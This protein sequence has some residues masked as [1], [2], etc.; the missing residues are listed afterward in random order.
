MLKNVPTLRK[1][2]KCGKKFLPVD[3]G[4]PDLDRSEVSGYKTLTVKK[5]FHTHFRGLVISHSIFHIELWLFI[6]VSASHLLLTLTA[7][8]STHPSPDPEPRTRTPRPRPKPK[9]G[10]CAFHSSPES[11]PWPQGQTG[12]LI[13]LALT[14]QTNRLKRKPTPPSI[15]CSNGTGSNLIN[16]IL[17]IVILHASKPNPMRLCPMYVL[18]MYSIKIRSGR[19]QSPNSQSPSP[20]TNLK[21]A[22]YNW[23]P[24]AAIDLTWWCLSLM[25]SWILIHRK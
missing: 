1:C 22:Y 11:W 25:L 2:E 16:L 9:G 18:Q 23:L 8:H 7:L 15:P 3:P 6:E 5:C 4:W 21:C 17:T 12:L 20:N 19:S 14:P 13:D 10:N 24:Q